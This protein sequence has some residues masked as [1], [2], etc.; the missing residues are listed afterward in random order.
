MRKWFTGENPPIGIIICPDKDKR[1]VEYALR[2]SS[3]PIGVTTYTVVPNCQPL[4]AANYPRPN[5]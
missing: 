5:L 2:T 1:V 3:P 4:I